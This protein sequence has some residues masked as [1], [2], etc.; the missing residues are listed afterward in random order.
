VPSCPIGRIVVAC[1]F[2]ATGR[3]SAPIERRRI[4]ESAIMNLIG[5]RSALIANVC[6][7]VVAFAVIAEGAY[8][9]HECFGYYR[10]QDIWAFLTPAIVMFII[11][12]RIFSFCFLA[13][14]VALF[15]QMF[16]QAE[17]FILS[18]MHAETDLVILLET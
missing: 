10:P 15:I 8:I 7:L 11:R 6:A 2:G 5:S 9:V 14:F 12:N 4:S 3:F 13:L 17:A 18:P 16:Y 1:E